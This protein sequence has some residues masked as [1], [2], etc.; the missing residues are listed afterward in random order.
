MPIRTWILAATAMLALGS[1]TGAAAQQQ[2]SLAVQPA[3]DQ[4]IIRYD[5]FAGDALQRQFDVSVVNVGDRPCAG[6]VRA[7]LAGE[8][9]GLRSVDGRERIP[10]ALVDERHGADI[11]PRTGANAPRLNAH[12]VAL[13]PGE[14]ALLRFTFAADPTGTPSRGLYSQNV[15]LLLEHANGL[16]AGEHPI[17]LAL[18]VAPAAAIGLKGQFQ[19]SN[20]VAR[21]ELGELSPGPRP[22]TAALYVMSTGGYRLSIRSANNGRLRLGTTDWYV[23]YTMGLGD[24]RFDLESP[25]SIDVVSTRARSDDYPLSID[26]GSVSGR[27]AGEYTDVVTFT[28][29]AL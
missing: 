11:T 10:Y 22:L 15:R 8:E 14:R 24:R 26:I 7:E 1:A 16:V 25:G 20:G 28:V 2:C 13:R 29:A 5:P 6:A 18:E 21:I 19:R 3:E 17:T 9:Y 27:R 12:P 4:W 23:D